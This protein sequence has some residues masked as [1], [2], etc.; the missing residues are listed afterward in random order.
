MLYEVYFRYQKTRNQP[1]S[2]TYE[3]MTNV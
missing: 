3:N 2:T 1:K